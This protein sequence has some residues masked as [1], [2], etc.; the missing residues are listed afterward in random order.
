MTVRLAVERTSARKRD[1]LL[2]KCKTIRN[3][4]P[5]QAPPFSTHPSSKMPFSQQKPFVVPFVASLFPV[6]AC[7]A[8]SRS[9]P[10]RRLSGSKI[11]L[12][13]TEC[14]QPSPTRLRIATQNMNHELT[15]IAN[16][17]FSYSVANW[18]KIALQK[19]HAASFLEKM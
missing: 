1:V 4:E 14:Y 8:T 16:A 5:Y 2:P 7:N 3:P 15:R 10:N 6:A 12:C 18:K 9:S 13:T 17:F 19:L 11:L